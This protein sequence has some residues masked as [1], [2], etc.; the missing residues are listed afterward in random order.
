MHVQRAAAFGYNREAVT[1]ISTPLY[2]NTTLVGLFPALA[3]GGRLV[4]M[5]KFDA[6]EFLKVAE[7]ERVTHP[8]L[9]RSIIACLRSPTLA[10]S[11]SPPFA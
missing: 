3:A 8:M 1:L 5:K 2:S 6:L 10:I 11:T 7:R 9:V 4:L